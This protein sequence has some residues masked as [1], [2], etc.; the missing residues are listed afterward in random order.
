[1]KRAPAPLPG[2]LTRHQNATK[3]PPK[4]HQNI[5]TADHRLLPMIIETIL[6]MREREHLMIFV[7]A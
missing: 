3:T 2:A 6:K 1:V 7:A 4:R 5:V